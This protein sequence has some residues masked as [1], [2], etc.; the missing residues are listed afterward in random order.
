MS[1]GVLALD[2]VA[3]FVNIGRR[4]LYMRHDTFRQLLAVPAAVL[5]QDHDFVADMFGLPLGLYFQNALL[6]CKTKDELRNAAQQLGDA[7]R[8]A[9]FVSV[10]A[11]GLSSTTD[12]KAGRNS[13]LVHQNYK[14]RH[15]IERDHGLAKYFYTIENG[16]PRIELFECLRM[17]AADIVANAPMFNQAYAPSA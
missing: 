9:G 5:D 13:I 8:S 15:G 10:T 11:T 16:R 4:G 6:Y 7:F 2:H 3:G 14:D 12:E 1:F 17:P